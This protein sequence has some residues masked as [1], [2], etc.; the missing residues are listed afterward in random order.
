MCDD[1]VCDDDVC[2]DVCRMVCVRSSLNVF[3][4][5]SVCVLS[6]KQLVFLDAFS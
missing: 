4:K 5:V 1:D 6:Y 2:D 3:D